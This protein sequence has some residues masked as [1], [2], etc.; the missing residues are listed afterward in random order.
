MVIKGLHCTTFSKFSVAPHLQKKKNL[1][2]DKVGVSIKKV[3]DGK[4]IKQLTSKTM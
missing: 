2:I 4:L 1:P 3:R